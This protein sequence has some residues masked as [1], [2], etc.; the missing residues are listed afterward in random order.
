MHAW[1][2]GCMFGLWDAYLGSEMHIWALGCI[3]GLNFQDSHGHFPVSIGCGESGHQLYK[4]L[5]KIMPLVKMFTFFTLFRCFKMGILLFM[6]I[7]ALA[8]CLFK[9]YHDMA[10]RAY[11]PIRDIIREAAACTNCQLLKPSLASMS[12]YTFPTSPSPFHLCLC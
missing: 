12:K 9:A 1:A 4:H 8:A 6:A 7:P 3:Y 10:M 2:L 11:I 5:K